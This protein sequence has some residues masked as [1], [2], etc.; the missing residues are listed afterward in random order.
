[1]TG[2]EVHTDPITIRVPGVFAQEYE[3]LSHGDDDNLDASRRD[4][5]KAWK[6]SE[7]RKA[8]FGYVVVLT[9]SRELA[10]HFADR[11]LHIRWM[12]GARGDDTRGGIDG[13]DANVA[14]AAQKV[15]DRLA[16]SGIEPYDP[17]V[18]GIRPYSGD[19][20]PEQRARVA[21]HHK[22]MTE[23]KAAREKDRLSREMREAANKVLADQV[24]S[25]LEEAGHS[26]AEFDET[27]DVVAQG[28]RV[29]PVSGKAFIY[30]R[31]GP[32]TEKEDQL[33]RSAPNGDVWN[34]LV[35]EID[36][37]RL[38]V[39]EALLSSYTDVLASEGW[40]VERSTMTLSGEPFLRAT[41]PAQS[42]YRYS[43]GERE[44]MLAE[45]REAAADK[46]AH[47]QFAEE[48]IAYLTDGGDWR[49]DTAPTPPPGVS[50]VIETCL[51]HDIVAVLAR[52]DQDVHFEYR[53][54]YVVRRRNAQ[55][56]AD[57]RRTTSNPSGQ[58]EA[59]SEEQPEV[60]PSLGS[61]V[62]HVRTGEVV[63][64]L[65]EAQDGAPG[66]FTPIEE[67]TSMRDEELTRLD[68]VY[69]VFVCL[70]KKHTKCGKRWEQS[71]SGDWEW[72][73][74]GARQADHARITRSTDKRT[75]VAEYKHGEQVWPEPENRDSDAE[76]PANGS[77]SELELNEQQAEALRILFLRY[78]FQVTKGTGV[79]KATLKSLERLGLVEV[80]DFTETIW[81]GGMNNHKR[82]RTWTTA[83]TSTG[84][85]EAKKHGFQVHSEERCPQKESCGLH[86]PHLQNRIEEP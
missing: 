73:E 84:I 8:G 55:A 34:H 38:K 41:R 68:N 66:K 19:D 86:T 45:I 83:I 61:P 67:A 31:L 27:G 40:A 47:T 48:L 23:Q 79:H 51:E 35:A 60:L 17:L 63:G 37:R 33:V 53:R 30:A 85:A 15:L 12:N 32:L 70:A 24:S 13:A 54:R 3:D 64:Y 4:L 76:D 29:R 21:A 25:I 20:S 1:M 18:D 75:P 72:A 82:E 11:A 43:E 71:R 16:E 69:C 10:E 28:H 80:E 74:R 44:R 6:Q 39:V 81:K 50:E 36:A 9:L 7:T 77:Q 46:K 5:H 22:E 78:P 62:L 65:R 2:Q 52:K 56:R 59:S 49:D 42:P 14:R 58:P 57:R 26:A